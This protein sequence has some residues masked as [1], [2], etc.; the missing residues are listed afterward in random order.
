[1]LYLV[2]GGAGFVG[3]NIVEELV[4][5]GERVRV[6]DNFSTGKYEN[7]AEW[8][9][10]I[11][12]IEGDIRDI[13][14]VHRALAG[15]DYVLHQAALPSVERSIKD[16][17]LTN[18]VNVTGTLNV[19]TA[20][21]EA[22]V[23]RVV[24]ASSSSVY[25]NSNE[26]PKHEGIRLDPR[27]PYAVSKL[28]GEKYC[29]AFTTVFKLPTVV[30]RY[31]NVYGPRQDFSSPYAAVVP[32]FIVSLLQNIP[33]E[34]NGDGSQSRDFTFVGNVVRANIL[35][36]RSDAAVGRFMNVANGEQHTLIDL[37]QTL[38]T[39]VGTS[40]IQPLFTC[41]RSGEVKHSW[42]KI[43]LARELIG[44]HPEEGWLEGLQSAVQWY[45]TVVSRTNCSH[46][47]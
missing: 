4:H 45:R 44:Y 28:A 36:C 27:S 47:M 8:I 13:D 40:N 5:R 14:T 22:N 21:R 39:L 15:V 25:G 11:E 41:P 29:L 17:L 26:L 20:A 2:T 9:D 30:L 19:L 46:K 34:L 42:A 43:D 6:L 23:R 31:F 32:R 18:E 16:P 12:L 3:S 37:F 7:L 10:R 1:M 38:V 33:P 24:Y 35:A